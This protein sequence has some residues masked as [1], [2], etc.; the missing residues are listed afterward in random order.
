MGAQGNT[1]GDL[2]ETPGVFLCPVLF[3]IAG[4]DTFTESFG[5]S[6]SF[7]TAVLQLCRQ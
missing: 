3:F 4:G 5:I 6:S 2:T 7:P 1:P